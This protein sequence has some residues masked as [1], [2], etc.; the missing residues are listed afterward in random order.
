MISTEGAS[1]NVFVFVVCG[2]QEH[3]NALHYSLRALKQVSKNDIAVVTDPARNEIPVIHTKVIEVK[4]PPALNHHQASIFLKTALHKFL[5][6]GNNYCYLDTDVIALDN[7]VDEIFQHFY[8]P[9]TFAPDHCVMD[10]FSPSAIK[11]NCIEQYSKWVTELRGLFK[12]YKHLTRQSEDEIKKQKLL[13]DFEKIKT[14]KLNYAFITLQFWL[15]PFKFKLN[16]DA[17]LHKRKQVWLDANENAILYEK[18]DNAIAVIE[19]T[20][21]F[22]CDKVNRHLW[23]IYGHNVFDCRCNH[24]QEQIDKTFHIEVTDA[25]W[26]HWNGG[27]FLFNKQSHS[28]LNE[29][30]DKTMAIFE[31][32]NWKTRDQGTLIATVWKNH[33]QNHPTLPMMFNLIADYN[34]LTM[35][36]KGNLVFDLNEKQKDVKP[37]FIHVYHHWADKNWEVWQEVERKTG[38]V[39]EPQSNIINALWIGNKL[40]DLEMLTIQSFLSNG[41][42]FKLWLYEKLENILPKEVIIG[43][44]NEIIS[45][46]NIFAYRNTNKF[47]HGKGSYAGFSDI[48]R[49]KLL[50]EQGGWWVDM[51]VTC[52]KP[53]DFDRP[54]FFRDHHDLRV[55]GNVMKCPKGSVL[56]KLCYED[57]TREVNEFNIDWHKPV[58]ILNKHISLLQL[59]G[60]I[61][62]DVSNQDKW[63]I[64]SQYIWQK[65]I[66]PDNWYFIHWQNE[67]WRSK[68]ISKTDFYYRSALGELLCKYKLARM[69]KSTLKK[70]INTLRHSYFFRQLIT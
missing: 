1:K 14:N 67:E 10:K 19:S 41:H 36:H 37:H 6:A 3:I 56:M 57:A 25:K 52:L 40:S 15:S 44:A 17:I 28:F 62:K 65:D 11:C 45:R 61:Y 69:P 32:K 2:S 50:Y 47:G 31:N 54:Y 42:V 22:R 64:T 49:Y 20:T 5:P 59:T 16:D 33:L 23:T 29:W 48:F 43:D 70:A 7:Q 39:T 21:D 8:P 38:I 66:F 46:E 35:I 60:Y 51:D 53:F 9:I 18:E 13:D 30:H 68:K 12:K 24:L 26:H 4:T 27:V 55:V 63:D 34:H 58:D